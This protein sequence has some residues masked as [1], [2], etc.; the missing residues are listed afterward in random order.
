MNGPS[1]VLIRTLRQ[2][3]ILLLL[4]WLRRPP[5]KLLL[6]KA[7]RHAASLAQPRVHKRRD[8]QGYRKLTAAQ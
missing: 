1:S 3:R 5:P 6:S 7:E 8:T 2:F 4:L